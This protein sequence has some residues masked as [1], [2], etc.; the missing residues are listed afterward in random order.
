MD[1]PS[2]TLGAPPV[3]AVSIKFDPSGPSIPI[4]TQQHWISNGAGLTTTTPLTIEYALPKIFNE[5]YQD[6]LGDMLYAYSDLSDEYQIQINENINQANFGTCETGGGVC[7]KCSFLP[8]ELND[9]LCN[10]VAI[11]TPP[12]GNYPVIIR[13]RMPGTTNNWGSEWIINLP[14]N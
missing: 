4:I 8:G 7:D 1:R 3:K 5:D 2:A 11:L 6:V 13:Y 10:Q 14:K 9:A 12:N